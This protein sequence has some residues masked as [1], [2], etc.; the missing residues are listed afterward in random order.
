[1]IIAWT[2]IGTL[3]IVVLIRILT[4]IEINRL[5][6]EIPKAPETVM[7]EK[8]LIVDDDEDFAHSVSLMLSDDYQTIT[9]HDRNEA[10]LAI[11]NGG[12]HLALVDLKLGRES[13]MRLLQTIKNVSPETVCIIVTGYG[14]D[15]TEE[16]SMKSGAWSYMVK[17]VDPKILFD[18]IRSG[19][20][21]AHNGHI[22]QKTV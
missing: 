19:L 1:M 4:D 12:V 3:I 6:Q 11:R 16:Q 8:V 14:T 17:P 9:A 10:V 20:Q 22:K 13:G 7:K 5:K 2:L 21:W 15:K 18:V